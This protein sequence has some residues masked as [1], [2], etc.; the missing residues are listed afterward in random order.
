MCSVE[1]AK[2]GQTSG[3]KIYLGSLLPGYPMRTQ[4]P[5]AGLGVTKT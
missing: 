4:I 1:M 5:A 3:S 2:E